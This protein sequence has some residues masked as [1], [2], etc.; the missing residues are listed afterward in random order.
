MKD[1]Y[2]SLNE[3]TLKDT[4]DGDNMYT[5][6][7]CGR[8]V[9]AEK[10]ACFRQLPKILCFNT[11]RY[12]FNMITM[13]KEKVNTH[14]S[15]PLELNMTG[16]METNLITANNTNNT[17]NTKNTNTISQDQDQDQDQDQFIYELIG[18]T[19][20]TGTAEGGHY[21][22]FIRDRDYS[23]TD[24][25]TTTTTTT[26]TSQ[27][28]PKWYLFNDAEVK[29]FDA[30]TQLA[31]ECFGGET[32]S[33]TYDSS[34]DKYTDLSV[35]KSNSAYMLFY[36][37][38]KRRKKE[39]TQ[40]K[41]TTTTTTTNQNQDLFQT[42]WLENERFI[43]DRHIFEHGYFAFV[44]QMCEYVPRSLL[45]RD[46]QEQASMLALKLSVTFLLETYVVSREK[47]S[48]LAWLELTLSLLSVNSQRGAPLWFIDYLLSSSEDNNNNNNNNE[49]LT[50]LLL[51]CSLTSIRQMF[52]KLVVQALTLAFNDDNNNNNKHKVNTFLQS[53]LKLLETSQFTMRH[54]TEYFGLLYEFARLGSD[55]SLMLIR[56]D[57][58]G[59]CVTFYLTNRRSSHIGSRR[60]RR[61]VVNKD[62]KNN[63]DKDKSKT[64]EKKKKKKKKKLKKKTKRAYVVEMKR[65]TSSSSRSS[66]VDFDSEE[67]NDD[68]QND[69][70]QLEDQ[71][72]EQTSSS[73]LSDDN[74][75]E[76]EEEEEEDQEDDIIPL[77]DQKSK[78]KVLEKII[79]LICLLCEEHSLYVHSQHHLDVHQDGVHHD[80]NNVTLKLNLNFFHKAILDKAN[81]KDIAAT[82]FAL[83]RSNHC[84]SSHDA[85][86]APAAAANS[87]SKSL[88]FK[89]IN[90]CCKSIKRLQ[91]NTTT[92]ENE[93]CV[94]FF[95][96][97]WNISLLKQTIIT[98][99]NN[100][101]TTTTTTP[102][103][104]RKRVSSP[105]PECA[106]CI[107]CQNNRVD[108]D[109]D[110]DSN[111]NNNNN[112][113]MTHLVIERLE[114]LLEC[115]PYHTLQ[116]L[117]T[118]CLTNRFIQRWL[119]D[120]MNI[121][122]KRLLVIHRQTNV[123]FSAAI[124]LVN[125]VPNR[126]FR[127][128]FTSNRNML[129]PFKPPTPPSTPSTPELESAE[130]T[131]LLFNY[132]FHSQQ[133]KSVLHQI[134]KFLFSII[135]DITQFLFN[136]RNE[137]QQNNKTSSSSSSSSSSSCSQRRQ[138]S[139]SNRLIQYFTFLIYCMT[140]RQEKQLFTSHE[141]AIDKF[142]TLYYPHIANEHVYTNLNKQ[143]AVHFLYQ[144]VVNCPQNVEYLF[145]TS[146]S[147]SSS[148]IVRELAIC[149][150][151]V[152]HEDCD[153][154]S[155]NRQCLHPYYA[156][157]RLLCMGSKAYSREII[158]HVQQY[159]DWA[160]KHILPYSM[161]YPLAVQELN[162]C[163]QLFL[164]FQCGGEA[165]A[166]ATAAARTSSQLESSQPIEI[167]NE[168]EQQ[169]EQQ[170]QQ[171][172]QIK[173]NLKER[174]ANTCLLNGDIDVKQSWQSI[175]LVTKSIMQDIDDATLV[176]T[177][178]GL[179]V[180]STCFF[181]VC[182][183]YQNGY[184]H[185]VIINN[186]D[187]STSNHNNNQNNNNF[188]NSFS[189]D[190]C[191]SIQMLM[192][193][194]DAVKHHLDK[195]SDGISQ[196]IQA[197]K[198]KYEVC[199]RALHL[200]NFNNQI[201]VRS[202]ALDLVRI[203]V[204]ISPNEVMQFVI[205]LIHSC[206]FGPSSHILLTYSSSSNSTN[207]CK[208][209]Q[210][211]QQQ[212]LSQAVHLMGVHFPISSKKLTHAQYSSCL[213]NNN[214]QPPARQH[215]NSFLPLVFTP[216]VHL[217]GG[218]GGI[219]VASQQ[220]E[221]ALLD[222]Y[223][224]FLTFFDW[225]CRDYFCR[226]TSSSSSQSNEN[227]NTF[228][229]QSSKQLVDLILFTSQQFLPLNISFIS[230]I[231]SMLSLSQSS[232]S[233]PPPLSLNAEFFSLIAESP[234]TSSFLI[235]KKK[236]KDKPSLERFSPSPRQKGL[237]RVC[238]ASH[239]HI[240]L[241]HDLIK[242]SDS[243]AYRA[244]LPLTKRIK[245][246]L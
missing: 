103:K 171:L 161:Q 100:E 130:R 239:G 128:T 25:T 115:A 134:I 213:N 58:I 43:N 207:S 196:I 160:F 200:V 118:A 135:D 162:K 245:I 50:K 227:N 214:K 64:K 229:R 226:R 83:M 218:G 33:K 15:F 151:A 145:S 8:K 73:C 141:R 127:E 236:K 122:V 26:T 74:D 241:E 211:Q 215:F 18:V 34:T 55:Q 99:K 221:K 189:F 3:I 59:K 180:L 65:S 19:V 16:Y 68:D 184:S 40:D 186:N 72:E 216:H 45:L 224:P 146:S 91:L 112:N 173:T 244:M 6:S 123:R 187:S 149:T 21:Y 36:E 23:G 105:S 212:L 246:L 13:L 158:T 101:T 29:A 178:R 242:S 90:M 10:R 56:A 233:P 157:M 208:T 205:T 48:L 78:L 154:I 114:F 20:H 107:K 191:E 63:N 225:L 30:S 1:I 67:F 193:L 62:T 17:N 170:S 228:L 168:T 172:A 69:D 140:S 94:P 143:V 182:T 102:S 133:C 82:L 87:S 7:Q 198:E 41:T 71:E 110:S 113:N 38:T 2:D 28:H 79:S 195:R 159:F 32:T 138:A 153:L 109:S 209:Q 108:S 139:T 92:S 235:T 219:V 57:A 44:W 81:L 217:N 106:D 220:E 116:W 163:L 231:T 88:A 155:Y 85:P 169:Q 76:E 243:Y 126:L 60:R 75:Q 42:I 35:E 5:C 210:Q 98:N 51:K 12:T 53:Y 120:H 240:Y 199:K 142:W 70:D 37:Q 125:L 197:W 132:D 183:L 188:T 39:N 129:V 54:M 192:Q 52:V 204:A 166:A 104:R 156:T 232:Q 137:K 237:L 31:S 11:M 179:S 46:D 230:Y 201:E 150:V 202:R 27:S 9:R 190:L 203:I 165:A 89:F 131:E 24:T 136:D 167:D 47:P 111:N 61:G 222:A 119:L 124:L 86:A 121:W 117:G 177:R 238:S 148:S 144:T 97:L 66:S 194:C 77:H 223:L 22:S 152:D 181:H 175:L 206:Y 147:S 84:R 176:L 185:G 93:R 96:I 80:D 4:L 234:H 95:K 174:L 49:L 14:F 164:S